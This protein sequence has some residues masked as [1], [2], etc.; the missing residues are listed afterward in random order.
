MLNDPAS[1][2]YSEN[3]GL[4][5]RMFC[6]GLARTEIAK[7]SAPEQPLAKITS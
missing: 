2:L 3:P 7:S 1:V 6:P 4:G 5:T